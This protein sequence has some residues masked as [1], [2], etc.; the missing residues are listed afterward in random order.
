[1]ILETGGVRKVRWGE[2]GKGNRGGARVVYLAG[3]RDDGF[4]LG[5]GQS[6]SPVR[7]QRN[8]YIAGR[9]HLVNR[10]G[11]FVSVNRGIDVEGGPE[12]DA[13]GTEKEPMIPQ[14][15]VGFVDRDAKDHAAEQ[16]YCESASARA[17][18]CKGTFPKEDVWCMTCKGKA[19]SSRE[20]LSQGKGYR[21]GA[22]HS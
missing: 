13:L 16:F 14:M 2:K 4:R 1:V 17:R 7:L 21:Y 22:W 3:F 6:V 9:F 10:Q 18:G 19:A 11:E 20:G 5:G 8:R 15:V 12:G